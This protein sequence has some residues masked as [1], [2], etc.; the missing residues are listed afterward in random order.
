MYQNILIEK[1]DHFGRGLAHINNKV[2]FIKNALPEEIVDIKIIKETK[3]YAE[4]QVLKYHQ[5]SS[6]RIK[7]PCPY[8]NQCGGCA[9]MY[10]NYDDTINFKSTKVKELIAKNSIP[11]EKNIPV[12]QNPEPLY[13]RNKL[14]L[15]IISGK[16][17]FY[18]EK[19][20]HLIPIKECLI[21]DK[22]I[23]EFIQN[24]QL[25]NI[26]NGDI[27]IRTNKNH[28]I[29]LVINTKEENYNI[30]IAQLKAKIKLIG[31]VYND[32]TIYGNNFYYERIGGFLFKISYN[33]FFQVNPYITE[34][35]FKLIKENITEESTVL[36]LYSG[37]GSLSIIASTKAQNVYSVEII[38]NAILNGLINAKLN[39]KTNINFMLGDVSNIVNNLILKFDTVIVDPP[40]K[41]L[42]NTT[43]DYLL[44][45]KPEK[46]IY[47]SCDVNTLMRDLKTL[48][49]EYNLTDYKILDMFSYTYHLESFVILNHKKG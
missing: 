3:K 26:K 36:D 25:L 32:K 35:L 17:G 49:K 5:L 21:A 33:S 24:Y 13:Y 41:G 22:T 12:I 2:I 37:V 14:S 4:A 9:L 16:I 42:D 28:E 43:I 46:I 10:Y 29:L 38:K 20:H 27:T 18:E 6:K 44:K 23:N 7:S 39:K 1:L 48:L 15:K 45:T 40:R 34:E 19:S 47:I 11:Y 31:I 30:D 8:F